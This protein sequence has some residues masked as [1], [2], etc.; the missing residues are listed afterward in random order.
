MLDFT[1][2]PMSCFLNLFLDLSYFTGAHVDHSHLLDC[3]GFLGGDI[4]LTYMVSANLNCFVIMFPVQGKPFNSRRSRLPQGWTHC[5]FISSVSSAHPGMLPQRILRAHSPRRTAP[6]LFAIQLG[7][8]QLLNH[9]PA[10]LP[11][12]PLVSRHFSHRCR[13]C[14]MR[15]CTDGCTTG[16]PEKIVCMCIQHMYRQVCMW[17]ECIHLSVSM[18]SLLKL[19]HFILP[20]ASKC[21][22]SFIAYGQG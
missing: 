19:L 18:Y 17:E 9:S 1:V 12:Q 22:F 8:T 15:I 2:L 14:I 7:S 6:P 3:S 16:L 13:P 5:L 4:L 11:A 10:P 21:F 20:P